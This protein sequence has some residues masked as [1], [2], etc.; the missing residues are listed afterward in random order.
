MVGGRRILTLNS[1]IRVNQIEVSR[2][3]NE[4]VDEADRHTPENVAVLRRSFAAG[5]PGA[6]MTWAFSWR[7][8]HDQRDNYRQI[9]KLVARFHEQYGDDVTFIPGH[10][11][12]STFGEQ[13]RVNPF[14][15]DAA[16]GR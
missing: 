10:G 5:W 2:D 16:L 4:G 8:L 15:G 11:P 1:I 13:R 14:V 6:P 9:R 3:R 12:L 7:A